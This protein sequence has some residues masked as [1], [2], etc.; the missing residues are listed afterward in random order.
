M[1]VNYCGVIAAN[2]HKHRN[3]HSRRSYSYRMKNTKPNMDPWGTLSF[4]T[5]KSKKCS[6]IFSSTF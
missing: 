3:A 2:K 6:L 5:L 1:C 4:V